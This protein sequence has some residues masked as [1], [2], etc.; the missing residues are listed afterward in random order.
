MIE[1]GIPTIAPFMQ[2]TGRW[3]E[4]IISTLNK[5]STAY[6]EDGAKHAWDS[7][8]FNNDERL[9]NV[10]RSNIKQFGYDMFMFALSG[11]II[12]VIIGALLKDIDK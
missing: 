11:A 4:G 8:W 12:S 5:L 6:F 10:Y 2:W 7:V 3:Q 9:R 1:R